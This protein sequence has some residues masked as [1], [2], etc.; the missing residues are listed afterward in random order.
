MTAPIPTA[1]APRTGGNGGGGPD[2][3]VTA[4][5]ACVWRKDGA[6]RQVVVADLD[7]VVRSGQVHAL[8]GDNGTGKS[9]ILL[10]VLGLLPSTL[11]VRSCTVGY[12]PQ[13]LVPSPHLPLSVGDLCRWAPPGR[14]VAVE[15]ALDAAGLAGRVSPHRALSALSGGELARLL[16]AL[17]VLPRPAL[18]LLDEP[19][20]SL[21]AAGRAIIDG[22]IRRA[23]DD[24]SGVLLVSHDE[25]QV[26]ALADV[27]VRIPVR[28]E[29]A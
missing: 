13:R 12:A 27:V 19:A 8:V 22:L 29:P 24:G 1:T 2:A 18:C 15:A 11:Q 14:R 5:R 17:A 26:A 25:R 23:R 20:A 16:T 6:E 21:D 10:A 3:L 28:A 9:S 4:Q 7:F